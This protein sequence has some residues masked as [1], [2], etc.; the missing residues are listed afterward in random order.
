MGKGTPKK[1]A[2]ETPVNPAEKEPWPKVR[3]GDV[4]EFYRGLTY[5]KKDEVPSS[6][7]VVLRSN[8]ID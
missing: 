3:L 7:N 8:N 6:H 5:S 4:C 1:T 2:F